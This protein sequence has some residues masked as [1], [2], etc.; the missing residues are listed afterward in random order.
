MK[1]FADIKRR[2]V[3]GATLVMERNDWS[4]LGRVNPLLGL[5]RKIAKS[6][7]NGVQFEPHTENATGS[8]FQFPSAAMVF[9]INENAF[10]VQLH[11]DDNSK[12]MIYRFI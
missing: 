5:S 11:P 2:L 4:I 9:V 10:G 1:T 6:Q 8:L 3:V 12:V 7:S